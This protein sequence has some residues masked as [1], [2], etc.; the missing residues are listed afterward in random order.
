MNKLL[1]DMNQ[2]NLD[3]VTYLN[4]LLKLVRRC[5]SYYF[6]KLKQYLNSVE[7]R[8][9]LNI[10]HTQRHKGEKNKQTLHSEKLLV[11]QKKENRNFTTIWL[12]IRVK[13]LKI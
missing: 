11:K 13:I 5:S 6:E 2:I 12:R 4:K 7:F 3:Y 1:Y 10:K 9:H 8:K